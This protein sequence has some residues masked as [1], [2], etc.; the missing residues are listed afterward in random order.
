MAIDPGV[1]GWGGGSV[2]L[3][4][5]PLLFKA[6]CEEKVNGCWSVVNI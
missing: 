5:A 1:G 3:R 4:G 6:R 2:G